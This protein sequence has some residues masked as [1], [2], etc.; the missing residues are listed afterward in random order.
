[1]SALRA[2]GRFWWDFLVGDDWKVAAAVAVT[3]GAGA[4]VAAATASGAGWL[5]PALGAAV[6]AVFVAALVVDVRRG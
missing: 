1:L 5:A 3:L 4:L 6:L 2:L